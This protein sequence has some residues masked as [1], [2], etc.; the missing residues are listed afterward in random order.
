MNSDV[1]MERV[2]NGDIVVIVNII[3]L[4]ALTSSTVVSTW[5]I[6]FIWS[7]ELNINLFKVKGKGK[8]GKGLATYVTSSALQ[9]RKWKLVGVS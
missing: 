6:F 5:R 1:M 3:V 4:T 7:P 2:L 8:N 9:S